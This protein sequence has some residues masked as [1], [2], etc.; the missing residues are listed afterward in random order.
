[1]AWLR[2][3][4]ER[5]SDKLSHL[6]RTIERGGETIEET[7]L[8]FDLSDL[9]WRIERSLNLYGAAYLFKKRNRRD[10]VMAVTWL[11]PTTIEPLDDE[12]RGL[13]AFQRNLS[14]SIVYPVEDGMSPDIAWVW[15]PGMRETK[16]G[17][18]LSAAVK[19]PGEV[20]R[21]LDKFSDSFFDQGA[22]PITL[23]RI[24]SSTRDAER[25]RLESRMERIATGVRN[26]FRPVAVRADVEVERLGTIPADL[27]MAEL[28]DGKRDAI[29]AAP[30]VPIS[31]VSGTAVNYATAQQEASNFVSNVISPRASIIERQLNK[32][33][34]E[35]LELVL[36]FQPEQLPEMQRDEVQSSA[37]FV[38]LRNGG[39]SRE[40]S[41][42]FL[43]YTAGDLPDDIE[44]FEEVPEALQ[45]FDGNNSDNNNDAGDIP[46]AQI[47]D[48]KTRDLARWQRKAKKALK[49]SK[50]ASVPFS[51]EF[52]PAH[53][54]EAISNLLT[55]A[56]TVEEVE[57]A[58]VVAPFLSF[59]GYP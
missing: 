40:A 44:M 30:G 9:L 42:Y 15:L 26:A 48:T 50:S 3:C 1:V 29:L 36:R 47:D 12:R 52:I 27:A 43:G 8:P 20:L 35:P 2:A 25:D 28:T 13:Y 16:P 34:F 49:A 55:D 39:M 6:P 53:E 56:T 22:M 32:H 31:L 57:A 46:L 7:V 11:D 41:A 18:P 17:D 21:S 4:Y 58:F 24:P 54:H 51:S 37:A 45:N 19:L 10:D 23:L 59:E 33:I 14:K 5:R 38:N